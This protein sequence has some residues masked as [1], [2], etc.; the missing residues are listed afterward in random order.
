MQ[1]GEEMI[2]VELVLEDVG[3]QQLRIPQGR[4]NWDLP[5]V[6]PAGTDT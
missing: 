5:Y 3:S 6:I 1:K 4:S 2:V